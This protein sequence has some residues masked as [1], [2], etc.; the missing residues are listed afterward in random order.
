MKK[1]LIED[2]SK[3]SNLDTNVWAK[4]FDNISALIEEYVYESRINLDSRTDIDLEFAILSLTNEDKKL[5]INFI[6]KSEMVK[7][8]KSI[9]QGNK[10]RL[11]VKLEKSVLNNILETFKEIC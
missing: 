3:I 10:S 5:K 1:R 7:S 6:P 11:K 4:I 8:L 9:E 2:L